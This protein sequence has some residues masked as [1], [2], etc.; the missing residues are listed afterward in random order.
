MSQLFA[1]KKGGIHPHDN[2]SLSENAAIEKLELPEN[3]FVPLAQ[4]IGAP[5]R[6][7]V[8]KGD[9]VK[10][11]QIIAEPAGFVSTY[12]HSPITGKV[13]K[14]LEIP[15]AGGD[16]VKAIQ[17]S[18]TGDEDDWAE[19]INLDATEVDWSR[20][21]DFLELIKKAG[22]VGLGGAAFPT[23]VKLSP[24]PDA[25]VDVLVL[26]GAECEPY[27]TSDYRL[28]LEH[29]R[30]IMEGIRILMKILKVSSA[31]VGIEDNKPKAFEAMKAAAPAGVEVQLCRTRYPQGA[32]K[33]LIEALTGRRVP[34]GKLPF[35][36]GV[37]VQNVGT[38]FAVYEA[39]AK[40]KPLIERVV[41]VTGRAAAN[42]GNF[43]VRMG[44]PVE[45][46]LQKVGS[47]P[48]MVRAMVAG[49]P[50]MGRTFRYPEIPIVKASSGILVLSAEEMQVF[51]EQDC[52]RC[53]RCVDA[54][55]MNLL[56]CDIA[57]L[58]EFSQWEAAR[59]AD[60]CVE[61]GCCQS[62]CPSKRFLV[63]W[64]RLAKAQR[65]KLKK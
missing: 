22:I 7:V 25:K 11:G 64:I 61:C 17:I 30:E 42:P 39:V 21:A 47:T 53:G 14:E 50:M 62:V 23:Q 16:R 36:V 6:L 40:N 5:A 9:E 18:R 57:N 63:Q 2:K 4:H 59:L 28:M 13:V 32:E 60:D 19:G 48:D 3:V 43:L 46:L 41:T 24:P 29:P 51:Q 56:P 27:L 26:N 49:G 37:V 34:P 35:S 52:I 33:Q 1:F 12:I 45:A 38:A 10:T 20:E 54:C 44:T 31:R 15:T 58:A 65:R 55:P 8:K